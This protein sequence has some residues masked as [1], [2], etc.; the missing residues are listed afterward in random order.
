MFIFA[1]KNI[2]DRVIEGINPFKTITIASACARVFRGCF[3]VKNTLGVIP[4]K[5]NNE[6]QSKICLAWLKWISHSEN[7]NIKHARNGSEYRV[8]DRYKVDGFYE[9]NGKKVLLNLHGC[10]FHGHPA[11]FKGHE[12]NR[13]KNVKMGDLYAETKRIDDAIQAMSP[14]SEYRTIC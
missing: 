14:E 13:T 8:G 9:K 11:C 1:T 12:M 3:L 6:S 2:C 4:P 5:I 7:V 10:Y